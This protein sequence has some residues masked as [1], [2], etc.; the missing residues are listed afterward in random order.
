MNNNYT[1]GWTVE[2]VIS[3]T[4]STINALYSNIIAF[5]RDCKFSS[6]FTA[7]DDNNSQSSVVKPILTKS[8]SNNSNSG[9]NSKKNSPE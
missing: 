3:V 5:Y 9:K 4:F 6:G 8:L 2:A 7:P 1:K